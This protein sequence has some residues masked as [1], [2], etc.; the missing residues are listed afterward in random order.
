MDFD[1][2]ALQKFADNSQL[3]AMCTVLA[4]LMA[5]DVL[6]G[7]VAAGIN[8]EA[9]STRMKDGL[10]RKLLEFVIVF[11]A[12][13]MQFVYPPMWSGT[14]MA[15]WYCGVE[16][17]SIIEKCQKA[18]VPMP[19]E[20][21]RRLSKINGSEADKPDRP[22]SLMNVTIAK[23]EATVPTAVVVPAVPVTPP[24]APETT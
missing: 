15:L 4:M 16:V 23:V 17:M 13:L 21:V 20:F 24:A 18:G 5:L 12:V 6:C 7:V 14:A 1:M 10:M 2:D 8:A 22:N 9:S 3:G 11:V 19:Q